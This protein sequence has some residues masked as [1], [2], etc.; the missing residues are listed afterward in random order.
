MIP[1]CKS[2][3]VAASRPCGDRVYFLTRYLLRPSGDSY[4]LLEVE[5][6][7]GT[8]GLMRPLMNERLLCPAGEV[9]VHQERVALAD[10]SLL[11]RLAR[12]HGRP[13]T[14]FFG[15]DEHVTFVLEPEAEPLLTV[16]VHDIEPPRPSL[17]SACAGLEA[18]GLTGELGLVFE[19][20]VRDIRD[21]G[22][23]VYPCRAAGLARSLDRDGPAGGERVACCQ[24][25]RELLREAYGAEP[26]LVE[27]CP[28]SAVEA[29]PFVARCCRAERTGLQTINGR[30]GVV[31][32]WGASPLTVLDALRSLAAA[33]GK[34]E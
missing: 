18:A 13:C 19:Y 9:A 14:V 30:L 20:H 5:P 15:H 31:V 26:E 11:V 23:G 33:W 7:P 1:E 27:T 4:D 29:E 28:C 32:H 21:L 8:P 12:E 34:R 10:R 6:D 25:G 17:A 16:H 24:T 3:G 22:A 2:V